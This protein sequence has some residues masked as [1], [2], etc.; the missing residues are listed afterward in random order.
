[1][2]PERFVEAPV[3]AINKLLKKLNMKIDDFDYFE[4]NEAF[5]VS[6]FL[7]NKLLGIDYNRMN[8]FGGAI[9]L[10]HP[11]GC[12]GARVVVTLINVLKKMG[13]KRGIASLCLGTGGGTA[14][15]VEVI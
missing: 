7:V 12:S 8:V 1:V 4:I 10:G 5:A 6:N 11:L 15:A 2:K 9:A 13:G 14:I 3:P